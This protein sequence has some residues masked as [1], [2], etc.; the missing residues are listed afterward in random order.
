LQLA[1][2]LV[3]VTAANHVPPLDIIFEIVLVL[4]SFDI[5]FPQI[6]S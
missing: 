2:I 6:I 3:S 5:P 4:V 1:P